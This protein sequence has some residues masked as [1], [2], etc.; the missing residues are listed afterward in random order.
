MY[1]SSDGYFELECWLIFDKTLDVLQRDIMRT[2]E[3]SRVEQT[4]LSQGLSKPSN[5]PPTPPTIRRPAS[6]EYAS[7]YRDGCHATWG[8]AIPVSTL[9]IY[10]PVSV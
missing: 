1:H 8:A 4:E 9:W 3:F 5:Y 2:A 6:H 10:S 7:I